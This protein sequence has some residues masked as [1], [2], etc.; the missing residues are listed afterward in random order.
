MTMR[1]AERSRSAAAGSPKRTMPAATLPTAPIYDSGTP[2]EN[3]LHSSGEQPIDL[4]LEISK[5]PS[6]PFPVID[7]FQVCA[8]HSLETEFVTIAIGGTFGENASRTLLEILPLPVV[9]H[10]QNPARAH[11]LPG[12]ETPPVWRR[13]ANLELCA[14]REFKPVGGDERGFV[15]LAA[16][17]DVKI[18]SLLADKPRAPCRSKSPRRT[19]GKQQCA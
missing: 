19:T 17:V 12:D 13:D 1:A 9:G 4:F 5:S 10:V 16:I 14:K 6:G 3:P 2:T 8:E 18:Y 15:L 11:D 7:R